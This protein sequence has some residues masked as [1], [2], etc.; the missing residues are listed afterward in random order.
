[1]DPQLPDNISQIIEKWLTAH[2]KFNLSEKNTY[3]E[4]KLSGFPR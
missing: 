4:A 1:M 3:N 2:V